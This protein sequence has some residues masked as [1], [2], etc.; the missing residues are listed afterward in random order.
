LPVGFARPIVRAAPAGPVARHRAAASSRVC[1]VTRE[2]RVPI[3]NIIVS[4]LVAT[5]IAQ[6]FGKGTGFAVGMVFL[7]F[8]FYPLLAFGDSTFGAPVLAPAQGGTRAI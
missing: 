2:R 4:F 3:A 8:V 1:G 6:R 5:G 7:P